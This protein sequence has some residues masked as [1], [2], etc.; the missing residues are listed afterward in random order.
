M[1]PYLGH[2]SLPVA[3]P[4]EAGQVLAGINIVEVVLDTT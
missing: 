1:F 2:L 3:V 4:D